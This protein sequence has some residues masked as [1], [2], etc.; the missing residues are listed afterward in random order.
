M[1]EQDSETDSLHSPDRGKMGRILYIVLLKERGF[2][3]ILLSSVMICFGGGAN[4]EGVSFLC[5]DEA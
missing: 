1:N 4:D 3:V 2:S 5:T